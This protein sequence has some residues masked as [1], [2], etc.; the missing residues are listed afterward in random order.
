MTDEEYKDHADKLK[1]VVDKTFQKVGEILGAAAKEVEIIYPE[2]S[3]PEI[4]KIKWL[5][6]T[7]VVNVLWGML[8][9]VRPIGVP[10]TTAS[11]GD[12]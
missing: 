6:Q 4:A 3:K 1:A 5:M 7:R 9:N 10:S 12:E 11:K 2:V 8:Y